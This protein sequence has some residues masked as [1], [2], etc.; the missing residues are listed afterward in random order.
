[1]LSTENIHFRRRRRR[2]AHA[3]LAA[4]D[5]DRDDDDGDDGDDDDGDDE[6]DENDD[7]GG[8]I[9]LDG[10]NRPKI[11]RLVVR[12]LRGR[13]HARPRP[14]LL[15]GRRIVELL[16]FEVRLDDLDLALRAPVALRVAGAR[17]DHL[18][19]CGAA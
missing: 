19:A 13:K 15:V 1:M 2:R 10:K 8:I 5:K 16:A 4:R 9:R 3:A 11:T 7:G 17:A 6:D 12:A 18:R 14:A